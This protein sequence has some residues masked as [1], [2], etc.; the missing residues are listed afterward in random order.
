[1]SSFS[2]GL[3]SATH[4][5]AVAVRTTSSSVTYGVLGQ[6]AG[7]LQRDVEAIVGTQ[8]RPRVA[9][10]GASSSALTLAALAMGLAGEWHV[11]MVPADLPSGAEGEVLSRLGADAVLVLP[12]RSEEP[13]ISGTP[14]VEATG[15]LHRIAER[16]GGTPRVTSLTSGSTGRPKLI[17]VDGYAMREFASWATSEL[18]VDKT[19]VWFEGGSLCS[20]MVINNVA[21]ALMGR[22]PLA[23]ASTSE[24][25][26]RE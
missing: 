21:C 8:T 12:G 14:T 25:P 18:S 23:L 20:D 4:R 6:L 11:T 10:V 16:F 7:G 17:E 24:Q 19:D 22:V 2:L 9:V 3:L 26:S 5:N 13:R 15:R 1:M